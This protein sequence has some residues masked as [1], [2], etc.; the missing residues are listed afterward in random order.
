MVESRKLPE[1]VRAL[2]ERP[3]YAHIATLMPDGSPHSVPVWIGMEGDQIAILTHPRSR[4]ALNMERDNRVAI[5]ITDN[6]HPNSMA[7]ISGRMSKRIDGD[8]AWTII[9]RLS[10]KYIGSPY[11]LRSNRVVFLIDPD[12]ATAKEF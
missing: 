5:S 12:T 8:A 7:L 6:D 11:P 3:N 2:L 1:A 4:K 10:N 9:D